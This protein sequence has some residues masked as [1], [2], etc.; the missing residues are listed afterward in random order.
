MKNQLAHLVLLFI[1]NEWT[2]FWV[3]IVGPLGEALAGAVLYQA[4]RGAARQPPTR[5][6]GAN[7]SHR[8]NC[9]DDCC[10]GDDCC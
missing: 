10:S 5:A 1:A 2:D 7:M 8:N 3:Y 6:K 9:D 4:V